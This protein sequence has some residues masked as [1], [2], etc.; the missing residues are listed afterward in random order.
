MM[1]VRHCCSPLCCIVC[2]TVGVQSTKECIISWDIPSGILWPAW[3]HLYVP[4]FLHAGVCVT[5][6]ASL[7]DFSFTWLKVSLFL[8]AFER[9][10]TLHTCSLWW[11]EEGDFSMRPVMHAKAME[12]ERN[13]RMLGC[14]L[15]KSRERLLDS[16]SWTKRYERGV[17][18]TT[19]A[20]PHP[21][22]QPHRLWCLYVGQ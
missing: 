4:A 16:S 5:S 15:C 7:C 13:T 6:V 20:H 3:S 21:L 17:T 12:K 22:C 14:F 18:P 2:F 9:N 8:P 19:S 11:T 1:M 10:S